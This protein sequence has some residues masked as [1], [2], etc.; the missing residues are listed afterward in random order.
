MDSRESLQKLPTFAK[1]KFSNASKSLY[2]EQ[3]DQASSR[4]SSRNQQKRTKKKGEP[5]A[6]KEI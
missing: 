4:E 3:D 2:Y 6:I 5:K 1:R